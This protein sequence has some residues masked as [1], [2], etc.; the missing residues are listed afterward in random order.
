M[1][2]PIRFQSLHPSC[3]PIPIHL[4]SDSRR[5]A[6]GRMG[7]RENFQKLIDKKQA[8]INSLEL[9]IREAK[10]YIQALQDS[11]KLLPRDANVNPGSSIEHELRPGTSLAKAR[12]VI[13]AAGSP[14][15]IAEILKAIGK[16]Q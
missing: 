10:S 8:E 7:L 9:T 4:Y 2:F 3:T 13:R 6:E 1:N 5:S 12:D 16:P 14:L 11:M 15:P